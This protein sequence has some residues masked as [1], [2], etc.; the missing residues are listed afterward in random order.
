[1]TSVTRGDVRYDKNM[2]VIT[3]K[4]R[5]IIDLQHVPE[6]AEVIVYSKQDFDHGGHKTSLTF[7]DSRQ[8][9]DFKFF[10]LTPEGLIAAIIENH[11]E[12]EG[13]IIHETLNEAYDQL[14]SI[15]KHFA[16]H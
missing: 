14:W 6:N 1:M 12:V 4:G 8:P 5:T 11:L 13:M 9:F 10:T 3:I 2:R 7:K 15:R 16:M